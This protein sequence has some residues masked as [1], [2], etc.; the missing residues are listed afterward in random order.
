MPVARRR[1]RWAG[2]LAALVL[3]ASPSVAQDVTESSLKAALIYNLAKFTEWPPD[4]LPPNAPFVACVHSDTKIDE[5]LERTVNGRL[6]IGRN[7]EVMRVELSG[8]LK[9]CHLLYVSGVTAE[10]VTRL[11]ARLRGMPI[12]TIIDSDAAATMGGVARVFLENGRMRFDLDFG[13]AKR[14]RLQLSA[15]LLSIASHVF[16]LPVAGAP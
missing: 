14:S 16:D 4:V 2:L 7:V 8:P 10:Q 9:R 5:A 1:G 11:A 3:G 15:K 13:L 6:L 12:L